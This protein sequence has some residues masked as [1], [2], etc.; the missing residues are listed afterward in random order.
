[1]AD[2]VQLRVG[3]Q[4]LVGGRSPNVNIRVGAVAQGLDTILA[5][6]NNFINKNNDLLDQLAIKK[7]KEAG[8]KAALEDD[9]FVPL[10]G[11]SLSARAFNLAGLDTFLNKI[12][13]QVAQ[14]IEQTFFDYQNDP[15]GFQEVLAARK[16]ALISNLPVAIQ[17]QFSAV[18]D[19]FSA[20]QMSK[21]RKNVNAEDIAEHKAAFM[22]AEIDLIR[23]VEEA[24]LEG[25]IGG[26][27]WGMVLFWDLLRRNGPEGT[28]IFSAEDMRVRARSLQV[29][30]ETNLILGQF[31]NLDVAGQREFM[32]D[33]M[34]NKGLEQLTGKDSM[35]NPDEKKALQDVLYGEFNR[36]IAFQGAADIEGEAFLRSQEVQLTEMFWMGNVSVY[37][38]LVEI[39]VMLGDTSGIQAMAQHMRGEPFNE[40]AEVLGAMRVA[41]I[42]GEAEGA[43]GLAFIRSFIGKGITPENY[44]EL[45]DQYLARFDAGTSFVQTNDWK[46]AMRRI[47]AI[48]GVERSPY[49]YIVPNPNTDVTAMQGDVTYLYER[50]RLLQEQFES[51]VMKRPPDI[52][53]E[54]TRYYLNLAELGEI[55]SKTDQFLAIFGKAA[56]G[57]GDLILESEK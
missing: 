10:D 8:I 36:N 11:A 47:D 17:G 56:S 40:D 27:E 31:R 12:S 53:R 34:D 29:K 15:V 43:G 35:F 51:G 26:I 41:I 22:K 3:R 25:N 57:R 45:R 30:S 32:I 19:Q 14:E 9:T 50:I 5:S 54:V 33:M 39:K 49:G 13:S 7:A 42:D 23:Q 28:G 46:E 37:E 38:N 20:T 44:L 1:M 52:L 4:S 18:F 2:P 16:R 24:A 6:L 48:R 21:I 55:D